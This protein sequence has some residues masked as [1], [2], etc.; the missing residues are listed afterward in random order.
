MSDPKQEQAND[1]TIQDAQRSTYDADRIREMRERL[2]TRGIDAPYVS[3]R[4]ALPAQH[5]QS[6]EPLRTVP[7]P[8]VAA[9]TPI[10]VPTAVS[11]KEA[12]MAKPK[13]S[14]RT[15]IIVV[16]TLFFVGALA[17]SAALMFFGDSTISGENIS[18]RAS[19]PLQIGGGEEFVFRI[20][21]ANQ[22]TVPIQAA[23]LILEYPRG[24]QSAGEK[25]EDLTIERRALDSIGAG[26]L[27]NVELAARVYGAENE[28]REIRARIEYRIEG[29]NATFEKYAEPL[30]FKIGTSPVV[31]AID[32]VKTVA[33]GQEIEL[34]LTVQS[35]SP[36]PISNLLVKMT[37]PD[38]FDF[39]SSDPQTVSGEDT[40]RIDELRSGEKAV[41]IVKGL[42]TGYESD[43]RQF[44][45][46]A[47]TADGN[48]TYAFGSQLATGRTEVTIE[49]PFLTID[50][51]INGNSEDVVIVGKEENAVVNITFTN[52]LDTVIY[53]G[54]VSVAL[55]GNAL[56]RFEVDVNNGFYDSSKNT[57]TWISAEESALREILPGGTNTFSF[58]IAPKES[59]GTG[60]ELELIV[61]ARGERI[62]DNRPTEEIRGTIERTIRIESV[63]ELSSDVYHETGP[64]TNSGPV[65]PVADTVTQYTLT[66]QTKAGANDITGAEVTATL[67]QYV[68]WLDLVSDGDAVSYNA[69]TRVLK[70][71]IGDLKG[72]ATAEVSMQV[73]FKPSTSQVGRTPTLLD[74]QRLRATDRFTGTVVRD[75]YPALTTRIS[76]ADG[77][78]ERDGQVRPP[79]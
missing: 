70:W 36:T 3:R 45:V 75:E 57:I 2:Y 26:E 41:I 8:V 42:L 46:A 5:V 6:T 53:D 77:E 15:W 72:S 38:G 11:Y 33:S 4:S 35:N 49:K 63:P 67:P 48:N 27:V 73:S 76:N 13:R 71:T 14:Y 50:T 74:V 44:G 61:T 62:F 7:P 40:W 23:T 65:P 25:V 66:L 37:Y 68:N 51:S 21:V 58:R 30:R 78:S 55:Q 60:A 12:S 52:S 1:V 69:T 64:F 39:T 16:S 17:L 32:A 47:G 34:A 22:N 43:A 79:S 28:E 18:I 19:G 29:S 56:N 24:T 10:P 9:P 54:E 59:V 20:A 31:L